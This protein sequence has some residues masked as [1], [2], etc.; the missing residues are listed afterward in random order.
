LSGL[1]KFDRRRWWA[2]GI[3]LGAVCLLATVGTHAIFIPFLG[4]P[5]FLVSLMLMYLPGVLFT[6]TGLFEFHEFGAS[7]LGWPG[8]AVVVL[9]YAALAL[10]IS[11]PFRAK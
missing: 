10:P 8:Y 2:F 9:F 7:P 3:V 4:G 11:W 1:F 5:V 6:W